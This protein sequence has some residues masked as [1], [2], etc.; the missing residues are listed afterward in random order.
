MQKLPFYRANKMK[1]GVAVSFNYGFNKDKTS[2][3]LYVNGIKQATWNES[4]KSGTFGANSSDP[5]KTINMKF[6]DTEVAGII[7]AVEKQG[8]WSAYHKS[9]NGVTTASLRPYIPEKVKQGADWVENTKKT[10]TGHSLVFKKEGGD[11]AISFPLTLSYDE[12]QL[13]VEYLRAGLQQKF[14]TVLATP[15][16][17]NGGQ[18]NNAPRNNSGASK[19]KPTPAPTEDAGDDDSNP[20]PDETGPADGSGDPETLF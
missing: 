1:T 15:A 19:P 6:S 10:A 3:D 11:E 18:Q 20:S 7:R 8:F 5:T 12:G 2:L 17:A 9:P 13:L 4:T 16:G 14:F